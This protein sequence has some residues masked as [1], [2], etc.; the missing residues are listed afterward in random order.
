[1]F[2]AMIQSPMGGERVEEVIFNIPSTMAC[3]PKLTAG[4]LRK[5]EGGC[6]PPMMIFDGFDPLLADTL[7]LGDGLIGMEH[8]ERYLDSFGRGEPFHI[9]EL[10]QPP[11]LVPKTGFHLSK[12]ALRI[13]KQDPLIPLN[14][15]Y[16]MLPMVDAEIE[17][18]SF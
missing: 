6:P 12:Q 7:S 14:N 15:G 8:P 18:G 1:M 11:G 2:K 5:R 9:P 16:D 3:F 17:K 4:E 10:N 13:L